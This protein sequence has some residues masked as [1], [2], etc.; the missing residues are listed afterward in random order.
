MAVEPM[1]R[2]QQILNSIRGDVGAGANESPAFLA[3]MESAARDQGFA[4]R[5]ADSMMPVPEASITPAATPE[6]VRVR[7]MRR[8]DIPA[9]TALLQQGRANGMPLRAGGMIPPEQPQGQPQQ[10]G[11]PVS[12]MSFPEWVR[13]N[14][15]ELQKRGKT[16]K[17]YELAQLQAEYAGYVDRTLNIEQIKSQR[18]QAE[19]ALRRAGIFGVGAGAGGGN[20]AAMLKEAAAEELIKTGRPGRWYNAYRMMQAPS[21]SRDPFRRVVA[22]MWLTDPT[23]LD[24]KGFPK[25]GLLEAIQ[26]DRVRGWLAAYR[27]M[28]PIMRFASQ[29]VREEVQMLLLEHMPTA[30]EVFDAEAT[31]LSPE[32]KS[33]LLNLIGTPSE[34]RRARK[35]T[36]QGK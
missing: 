8:Q 12:V 2:H 23:D 13:A 15:A 20:G 27:A 36:Q 5:E 16:I 33:L 10:Q 6:R 18:M 32:D 26:R 3:A 21:S 1:E 29:E 31:G 7:R 9:A 35:W 34:L 28:E 24:S 19:A 11:G 30:D 14:H 25:K 22:E 4:Q 17:G